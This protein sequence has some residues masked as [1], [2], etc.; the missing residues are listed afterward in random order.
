M[1]VKILPSILDADPEAAQN[2][3]RLVDGLVDIVG[4]DIIDGKFADNITIGMDELIELTSEADFEVQLM[5]EEPI[6]Y[7]NQCRE[8]EVSS[9]L[10][11]IELMENQLA[12][13]HKA[14]EKGMLAGLALDLPTPI[15]FLD[16]GIIEEA[17][18]ILLMAVP[19]GFSDQEFDDGVLTKVQELRKSGFEKEIIVDGG[20]NEENIADCIKAGANTLAITSALWKAGDVATKLKQLQ[21]LAKEAV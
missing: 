11:H 12:F 14:K 3:L 17:D 21:K 7:V 4:I 10:G 9:V 19:A 13:L 18:K 15:D 20:V 1:D 8:A 2:K 16:E 5:V 6:G